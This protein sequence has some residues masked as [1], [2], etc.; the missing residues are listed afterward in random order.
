MKRFFRLISFVVLLYIYFILARYVLKTSEGLNSTQIDLCVSFF[1]VISFVLGQ[2]YVMRKQYQYFRKTQVKNIEYDSDKNRLMVSFKGGVIE[3]PKVDL[4]KFFWAERKDR[5]IFLIPFFDW[6]LVIPK[7]DLPLNLVKKKSKSTK[8]L[9]AKVSILRNAKYLSGESRNLLLKA[10][11]PQ[12]IIS[13]LAVVCLLILGG[14]LLEFVYVVVVALMILRFLLNLV[15]MNGKVG[16][17]RGLDIPR[18]FGD[19]YLYKV[20]DTKVFLDS[21]LI[22]F[23]YDSKTSTLI[24]YYEIY[25]YFRV[26]PMYD[27]KK[28]KKFE[29]AKPIKKG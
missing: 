4:E 24:T 6:T 16:R 15:M 23:A 13:L 2:F 7:S 26:I 9:L 3:I 21:S 20:E 10:F 11:I 29:A 28:L 19:T 22:R 27:Y 25:S 12:L 14:S 5:Y 18:E 8:T 17:E 1:S